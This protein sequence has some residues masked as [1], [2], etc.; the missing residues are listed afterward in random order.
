MTPEPT[1]ASIARRIR[2]LRCDRGW[3]LADVEKLSRGS[4]KAVVLASYERGDRSISLGR[5]IEIANLFSIPLHHLLEAP[6]KSAPSAVRTAMMIDLRRVR[7]LAKDPRKSGD[8]IFQTVSSLLAWVANRRCDW[9]GEIL[10]LRESD[11]GTLALMTLLSE[12]ELVN[13][14]VLNQLLITAPNRP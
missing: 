4:L 1:T 12:D 13:W 11:R 14:L 9:N 7:L 5:A 6:E 8:R 2:T 3:T 10:S